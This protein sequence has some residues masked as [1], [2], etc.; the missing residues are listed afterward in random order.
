M[1]V[2][3]AAWR[4]SRWERAKGAD[5]WRVFKPQAKAR[6]HVFGRGRH[7]SDLAGRN[8]GKDKPQGGARVRAEGGRDKASWMK[9]ERGREPPAAVLSPAQRLSQAAI[10][11]PCS[12]ADRARPSLEPRQEITAKSLVPIN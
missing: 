5:L 12:R 11:F 4:E 6:V 9:A 1:E 10:R 8:P 3:G 7:R 2:G